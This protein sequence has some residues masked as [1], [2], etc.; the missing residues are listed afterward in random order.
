VG[1]ADI[2]ISQNEFLFERNLIA[3]RDQ[4]IGGQSQK[5]E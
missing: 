3:R 1:L 4:M 2:G 5:I